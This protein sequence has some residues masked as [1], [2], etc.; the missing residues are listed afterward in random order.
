MFDYVDFRKKKGYHSNVSPCTIYP[1]KLACVAKIDKHNEHAIYHFMQSIPLGTIAP[2]YYGLWEAPGYLGMDK[3]DRE[4]RMQIDDNYNYIIMEDLMQGF[5]SPNFVDIKLGTRAS[6]VKT[7]KVSIER[8]A[9]LVASTTSSDFGFRVTDILCNK[10]RKGQTKK[11]NRK[12]IAYNISET[13]N[14]F[15]TFFFR[16]AL[17]S[18]FY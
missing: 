18:R 6:D 10:L 5:K 7:K 8:L 14:F 16:P 2:K 15:K 9:Y 11:P 3:K 17:K 4:K 12:V 13:N 1:Q